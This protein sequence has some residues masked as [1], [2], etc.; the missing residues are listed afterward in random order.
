MPNNCAQ[1]QDVDDRRAQRIKDLDEAF[2]FVIRDM[3]RLARGEVQPH[4][5]SQFARESLEG[6]ALI[7]KR[8][9]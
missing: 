3:A 1:F 8:L 7:T 6:A 9:G 2:C 5:V 4:R